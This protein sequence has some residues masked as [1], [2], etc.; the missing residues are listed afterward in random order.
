MI[1]DKKNNLL[2]IEGILKK[3][4]SKNLIQPVKIKKSITNI[5]NKKDQNTPSDI[6]SEYGE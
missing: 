5:K 1:I 6:S 4:I 3:R 2:L